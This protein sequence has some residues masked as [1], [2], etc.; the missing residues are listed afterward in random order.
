[1]AYRPELVHQAFTVE[2]YEDSDEDP[3]EVNFARAAALVL[4]LNDAEASVAMMRGI[5]A[6]YGHCARMDQTH[7]FTE[8]LDFYR[9]RD[10][11]EGLRGS[12][13]ER[14]AAVAETLLMTLSGYFSCDD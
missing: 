7:E 13:V 6:L 14:V 9:I 10:T 1:M 3:S 8:V 11:L 2:C 12:E 4:S 5:L